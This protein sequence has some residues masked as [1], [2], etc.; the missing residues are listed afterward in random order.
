MFQ[1]RSELV[2]EDIDVPHKDPNRGRRMRTLFKKLRDIMQVIFHYS[3]NER[4]VQAA[5]DKFDVTIEEERE[6]MRQDPGRNSSR[7]VIC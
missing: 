5:K 6:S 3:D 1:N 7:K 2:M 4:E